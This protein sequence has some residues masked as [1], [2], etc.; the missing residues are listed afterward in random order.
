MSSAGSNPFV[1]IVKRY[2]SEKKSRIP[3][4]LTDFL[5]YRMSLESQNSAHNLIYDVGK[6]CL[7]GFP[8][9]VNQIVSSVFTFEKV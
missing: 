7:L 3:D 4:M 1:E 9:I 2:L 5:S 8:N 6:P